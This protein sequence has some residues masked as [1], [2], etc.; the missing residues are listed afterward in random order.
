MGLRAEESSSRAKKQTFKTNKKQTN[1]KRTWFEWLPIH[2]WSTEHVF[3]FIEIN[4]Q[5]P[6]WTYSEGLSRKSCSF[7]I[8]SSEK[9]LCISA[10]L[11]PELLEK[12]D[13]Y[14]RMTGKTMMMPSKSKGKR[15]LKHII[16][17]YNE[18]Q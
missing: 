6:F 8:M 11:R 18:N 9:D 3:N 10:K 15:T 7:C 2:H 17:D 13:H 16:K 5:E 1:G 4:G 12:F 14:E